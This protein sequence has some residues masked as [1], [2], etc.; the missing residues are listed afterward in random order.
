MKWRLSIL[1]KKN[2]FILVDVTMKSKKLLDSFIAY[3]V[4]HP[5]ERFWQALRN[6]CGWGFVWVSKNELS[7]DIAYAQ[8][9]DTFYW[10]KNE[11]P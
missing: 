11:K 9:E 7:E 5:H 2:R 4:D 8:A 10:E 1:L 6:W 3:C